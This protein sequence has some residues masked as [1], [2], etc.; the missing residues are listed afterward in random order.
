MAN[1]D[2]SL[3][4]PDVSL[5]LHW[6]L[7]RLRVLTE[8]LRQLDVAEANHH[9]A[10]IGGAEAVWWVAALDEACEKWEPD[11]YNHRRDCDERGRMVG[12]LRWLRDRHTHQIP[13]SVSRDQ[14]ALFPGPPFHISAG[15]IWRQG[16]ELPAPDAGHT[17]SV[18][19][20]HYGDH[21]AGITVWKSCA[22]AVAWF[23]SEVAADGSAMSLA[24]TDGS[25]ALARLVV[26]RRTH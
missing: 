11:G 9:V 23:E 19:R 15:Y 7:V 26:D 22:Q 14:T 25:A 6:S 12:G 24:D 10:F 21:V 8:E 20:S 17:H 3:M 4:R 16:D 5:A 13:I 18:R 2:G 1:G